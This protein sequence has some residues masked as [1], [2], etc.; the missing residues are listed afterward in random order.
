MKQYSFGVYGH[1]R[2]ELIKLVIQVCQKNYRGKK[3]KKHNPCL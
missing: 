1:K 2:G 3:K